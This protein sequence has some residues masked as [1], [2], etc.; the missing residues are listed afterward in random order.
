MTYLQTHKFS[1][2]EFK[3]QCGIG[4]TYTDEEIAEFCREI[5]A[6][7]PA[8]VRQKLFSSV[9]HKFPWAAAARLREI[10]D[11]MAK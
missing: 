11:A 4:V 5:L 1:E 6:P 10:Y 3:T 8:A 7:A 9:S 2:A